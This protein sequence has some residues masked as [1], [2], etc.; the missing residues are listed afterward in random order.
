[1]DFKKNGDGSVTNFR[2]LAI[3][4]PYT[5]YAA[6]NTEKCSVECTVNNDSVQT[7][8]KILLHLQT[9]CILLFLL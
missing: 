5:K 3:P 4:A 9:S 6:V 8:R 1:M 7:P 2:L